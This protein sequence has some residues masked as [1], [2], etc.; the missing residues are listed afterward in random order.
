M[1]WN[2]VTRRKVDSIKAGRFGIRFDGMGWDAIEGVG[3]LKKWY[4]S[5]NGISEDF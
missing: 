2:L 1:K 5:E 4:Y 3:V